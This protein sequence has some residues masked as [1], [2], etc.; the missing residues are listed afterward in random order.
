MKIKRTQQFDLIELIN[1]I[2]KN[3][4][5]DKTF[6]GDTGEEIYVNNDREIQTVQGFDDMSNFTVDIMEE[7]TEDTDLYGLVK[8]KWL[9]HGAFGFERCLRGAA[10][11]N[12]YK[13]D[14]TH[15][16]Y[17][18]NEDMTMTLIWTKE[19]GPVE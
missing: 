9:G 10:S 19:K 7:I 15:A 3:D 4:I 13:D 14:D 8:Y 5:K 11:I 1:Y 12:N 18:Q 6:H 16:F 2:V 17:I